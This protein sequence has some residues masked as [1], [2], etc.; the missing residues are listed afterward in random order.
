MKHVF[1]LP[2]RIRVDECQIPQYTMEDIISALQSQT[3]VIENEFIL[4]TT[5]SNKIMGVIETKKVISNQ[6][7]ERTNARINQP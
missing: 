5:K 7:L 1:Y 6:V 4:D 2:I 3:A